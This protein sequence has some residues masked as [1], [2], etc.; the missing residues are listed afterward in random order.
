VTV[1]QLI[2]KLEKIRDHHGKRLPVVVDMVGANN[3]RPDA[4][5]SHVSVNNVD[6]EMI[7]WAVDD[8]F[9]R[10]DGS[11]RI[12]KVVTLCQR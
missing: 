7:G 10:E 12:R 1:N 9:I 5:Y 6:V 11:E 3:T 8:S 4:I 2:K